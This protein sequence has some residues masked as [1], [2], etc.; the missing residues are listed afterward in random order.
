MACVAIVISKQ[1]EDHHRVDV[2]LECEL[3]G[4]DLDGGEHTIVQI[5]GL[6]TSWARK[7]NVSSGVTTIFAPG[8]LIDDQAHQ[9]IIPSRAHIKVRS[10]SETDASFELD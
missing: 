4:D 2:P 9:M 7:N 5:E 10:T 6:T 8:T 1:F 3:L